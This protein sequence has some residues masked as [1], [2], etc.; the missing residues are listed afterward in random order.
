MS[1]RHI[2]F[3]ETEGTALQTLMRSLTGTHDDWQIVRV[4]EADAALE[5][6][7]QRDVLCADR[8]LWQRPRRMRHLSAP[9]PD[10]GPCSNTIRTVS[11]IT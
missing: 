5:V 4:A 10:P 3:V 2:L 6:L 7:S 1:S 11:G 8:E 9:D